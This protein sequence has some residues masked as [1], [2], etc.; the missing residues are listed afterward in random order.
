[1]GNDALA[2]GYR[3]SLT[4]EG[5]TYSTALIAGNATEAQIQ[6]AVNA[7]LGQIA[8]AVFTV[9]ESKNT[10]TVTVG[11]SLLGQNVNLLALQAQGASA[12]GSTVTRTFAVGDS[13]TNV[14]RFQSAYAQLLNG[15]N[16]VSVNA[17]DINVSYAN[18]AAGERYVVTFAGDLAAPYIDPKCLRVV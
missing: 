1:L 8:G 3:L 14:S 10:L 18:T 4:H 12:S 17:S 16:G 7:G 2:N 5:Q 15:H 6:S 11:G 13:A 9:S